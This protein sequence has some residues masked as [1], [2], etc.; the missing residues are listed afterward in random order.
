M[1]TTEEL[2]DEVQKKLEET[3]AIIEENIKSLS[4]E[5][6]ADVILVKR[7][8][9]LHVFECYALALKDIIVFKKM[10]KGWEL[11]P[12]ESSLR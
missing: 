1:G 8:E 4:N 12:S 10:F 6:D 7:T 9:L 2:N 5:K 11:H 3:L